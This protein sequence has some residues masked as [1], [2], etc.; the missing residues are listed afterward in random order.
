MGF[1]SSRSLSHAWDAQKVRGEN[2]LDLCD[3]T[4][5]TIAEEKRDGTNG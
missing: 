4:A 1:P 5:F 2:L 3:A